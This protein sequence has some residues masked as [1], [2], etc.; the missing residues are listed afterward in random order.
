ME[1][2]LEKAK[3]S[4]LAIGVDPNVE[5][6]II[7]IPSKNEGVDEEDIP[8]ATISPDSLCSSQEF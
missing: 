8:D 2:F 5:F 6:E 4:G 1:S 3:A 7:P